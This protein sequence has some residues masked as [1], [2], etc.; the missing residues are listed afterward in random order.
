MNI[1]AFRNEANVQLTVSIFY[2]FTYVVSI[3]EQKAPPGG[4]V[5]QI[6]RA[7]T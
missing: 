4:V 1:E 6:D 3:A 5:T 7:C 2:A